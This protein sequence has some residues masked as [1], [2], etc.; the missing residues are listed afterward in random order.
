MELFPAKRSLNVEPTCHSPVPIYL[1]LESPMTSREKPFLSNSVT[2]NAGA[3][4]EFE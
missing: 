1:N 4:D 3:L 2:R